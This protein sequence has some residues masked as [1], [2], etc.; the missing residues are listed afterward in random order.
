MLPIVNRLL[1]VKNG[2]AEEF[3]SNG[4][5]MVQFLLSYVG[6]DFV[7]EQGESLPLLDTTESPYLWKVETPSGARHVPSIACVVA[8]SNGGQTVDAHA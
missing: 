6:T 3:E 8:S 7:V 2:V 5:I 1:K 4:P